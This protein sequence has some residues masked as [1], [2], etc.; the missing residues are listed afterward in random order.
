M[1]LADYHVHTD[2]SSDS[3]SP[4]EDMVKQAIALG[5]NRICFTDHMDFDFPK[6]YEMR[7]VFDADKYLDQIKLLQQKYPQIQILKGIECGMQTGLGKQFE[8]LIHAYDFDFV[9]NSCHV[10]FNMD[11][12]YPEFWENRSEKE[13]VTA[14]FEQILANIK[15][16]Q[17]FDT[18]GHLDY[19]IRYSPS[20]G[21][22]F[23]PAD[24]WDILDEIL[25]T[26]IETGKGIEA[27]T[28]G[29]KYGLGTPHPRPEIIR[30]YKELGGEIITIGSD[31]HQ[32]PHIAYDFKKAEELLKEIG[33]RY[34]TVFENRKPVFLELD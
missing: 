16:F 8:D 7:F 21:S 13:G 18:C 17:N 23:S 12:Y 33:F 3:K 2:F 22:A 11:P 29:Y 27:N 6:Q 34:Y 4:M 15:E 31:G 24:Y 9:I 19:V 28:S 10:L 32:P 5:L 1:I 30:R 20:K 26:A 14:Y 25:K